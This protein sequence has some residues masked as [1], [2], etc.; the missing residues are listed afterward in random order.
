MRGNDNIMNKKQEHEIVIEYE[1]FGELPYDPKELFFSFDS[2]ISEKSI[3]A[4]LTGKTKFYYD[5]EYSPFKP[6]A[7]ANSDVSAHESTGK[8]I[9]RRE[10]AVRKKT[11]SCNGN[12]PLMS[13]EDAYVVLKHVL[14]KHM[15]YP[16]LD[17]IISE[18]TDEERQ[19]IKMPPIKA[20]R[21]IDRSLIN[22][23]VPLGISLFLAKAY[24]DAV[25]QLIDVHAAFELG[26][27]YYSARYSM[28]DYTK[29]AHFFVA[30]A[31]WG[32]W[33]AE[34]AL[35]RCYYYGKGIPQ[36]YECAFK[37]LIKCL[38][39]ENSVEACFLLGNLYLNGYYVEKDEEEG[40]CLYSKAYDIYDEDA[41]NTSSVIG[42]VMLNLGNCCL[43]GIGTE[44]NSARA[45]RWYQRAEYYFI[46]QKE[47]VSGFDMENMRRARKGQQ[48]ARRKILR[49]KF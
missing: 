21:Y 10:E 15:D 47:A 14:Y 18:I 33:Q 30:A 45:F 39:L 3:F 32:D 29:A 37:R 34:E 12:E 26:C 23:S 43:S 6:D 38:P 24:R 42:E 20:A 49:K 8:R 28:Q 16:E 25:Y 13:T 1:E 22:R 4:F 44:Q 5:E 19:S 48:N 31:K 7:Y 35:G 46:T 27:L 36:D 40:F 17:S 2:D 11:Y 9:P 41:D